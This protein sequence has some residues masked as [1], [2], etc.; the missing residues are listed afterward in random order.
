MPRLWID[1]PFA[2]FD[3]PLGQP[4]PWAG[5]GLMVLVGHDDRFTGL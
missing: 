5:V 3:P 4:T 1:L 2:D